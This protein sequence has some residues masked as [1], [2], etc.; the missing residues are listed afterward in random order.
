[1]VSTLVKGQI[2]FFVLISTTILRSQSSESSAGGDGMF[3]SSA[4]LERL[5]GTEAELVRALKD[6]IV[7]EEDRIAKLRT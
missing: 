2:L 7:Q 4:D 3:T 1:M 5:L 6:Y